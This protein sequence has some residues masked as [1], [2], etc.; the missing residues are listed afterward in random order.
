MIR[1]LIENVLAYAGSGTEAT[2]KV[3][4]SSADV[5]LEVEDTGSGIEADKLDSVRQRF[6]RGDV[7][8]KPGAGLGLPIVEEIGAL[9][10]GRLDLSAGKDDC[11][12]RVRVTFSTANRD[13]PSTKVR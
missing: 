6:V 9:F 8:G 12:L 3:F 13:Q 10:G 11:G 7:S 4:G 2:V 1:N 5:V